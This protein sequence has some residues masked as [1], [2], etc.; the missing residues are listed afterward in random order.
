MTGISSV[1]QIVAEMSLAS[2]SR[3]VVPLVDERPYTSECT[4]D[5]NVTEHRFN[6]SHR[7][8]SF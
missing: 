2:F 5:E 6:S 4:R 3:S 7:S 1:D 8:Q